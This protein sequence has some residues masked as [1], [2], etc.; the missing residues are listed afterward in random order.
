MFRMTTDK[1]HM[2]KHR[3]EVTVIEGHVQHFEL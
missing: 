1:A 2:R 3:K